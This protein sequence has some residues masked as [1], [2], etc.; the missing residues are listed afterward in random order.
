MQLLNPFKKFAALGSPAGATAGIAGL[1]T[2]S[3]EEA[4]HPEM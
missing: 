4:L 3:T 1:A 2:R